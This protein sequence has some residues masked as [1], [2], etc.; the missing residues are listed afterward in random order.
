MA[1]R[2]HVFGRCRPM[3]AREAGERAAVSMR[4]AEARCVVAHD[5]EQAAQRVL[6]GEM[7]LSE[8]KQ[9]TKEY[10]LDGVF[11][12]GDGQKE[13]YEG[14]GAPVLKDVLKGYNGA[15]ARGRGAAQHRAGERAWSWN[16]RGHGVWCAC[17]GRALA[18]PSRART[19]APRAWE[20]AALRRGVACLSPDELLATV[21][22]GR[23]GLRA[24]APRGAG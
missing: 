17:R 12:G 19:C 5:D 24:L 13:V 10:E 8:V 23:A 7:Q 18:A 21:A 20:A 16:E 2:V 15:R 4:A 11:D 3:V 22:Q 14:V 9:I 6:S 1:G